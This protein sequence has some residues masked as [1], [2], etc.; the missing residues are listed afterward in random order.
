MQ[1][2]NIAEQE[3]MWVSLLLVAASTQGEAGTSAPGETNEVPAHQV[4]PAFHIEVL[5]AKRTLELQERTVAAGNTE[6]Q[7]AMQ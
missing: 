1:T 6:T 5:P 2:K 7:G 3:Q 4:P